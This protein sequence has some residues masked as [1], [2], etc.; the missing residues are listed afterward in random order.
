[1]TLES[2]LKNNG[3]E[4]WLSSIAMPTKPAISRGN[5]YWRLSELVRFEEPQ[6]CLRLAIIFY[7]IELKMFV[8]LVKTTYI[9]VAK[10]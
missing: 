10:S 3:K 7:V 6:Q 5:G 4:N 9:C 2:I 8:S 1:M